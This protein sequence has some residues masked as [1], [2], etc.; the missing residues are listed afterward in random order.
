VPGADLS[1]S[2]HRK[3]AA[4]IRLREF[5]ETYMLKCLSLGILTT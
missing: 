5:L 4:A 1:S 3:L 2:D